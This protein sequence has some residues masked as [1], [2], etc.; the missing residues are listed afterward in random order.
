MER[1]YLAGDPVTDI[2][3]LRMKPSG[4]QHGQNPKFA[5]WVEEGGVNL[6]RNTL[7]SMGFTVDL[8][9]TEPGEERELRA[10]AELVCL[11]KKNGKEIEVNPPTQDNAI[12]PVSARVKHYDGYATQQDSKNVKSSAKRQET[13]NRPEA[14]DIVFL[15]DAGAVIRDTDLRAD[16]NKAASAKLILHK[17]HQALTHDSPIAKAVQ[18]LGAPE[19]NVL[20]V[21]AVDVRLEGT[22]M[23]GNLSWDAA[24][25]DITS[26][27]RRKSGFLAEALN[28]YDHVIIVFGVD[29]V[30]CIHH[31]GNDTKIT[32]IYHPTSAE[33][34]LALK[35]PG[36][37]YGWTNS[38][39]C[40]FLAEL[41]DSD[42]AFP[43]GSKDHLKAVLTNALASA[44][45]Y[46]NSD[47]K[48]PKLDE[49]GED[50]EWPGVTWSQS[51]F[52]KKKRK[53]PVSKQR[54]VH[55][56]R[57]E[58]FKAHA[59]TLQSITLD[60][61]ELMGTSDRPFRLI[62]FVP[63]KDS[64]LELAHQI[65]V[66]GNKIMRTLPSAKIGD[67]VTLD[68]GE[69]ESYRSLQRM[70]ENYLSND[71]NTK[72]I[73]IGVFGPPGSGKSFGIKQIAKTMKI[74]I[75]E[76]NLSEAD[77]N[78]LP[79]YFHEIRDICLKGETPLCFFDEFD[80][81]GR[82][83]V[84]RFLAPMQDGEFRDGPRV[85]PVGRAILVFAGGT[86]QSVA[87]FLDRQEDGETTPD[88]KTKKVP[89]FV[90]RLGAT[91]DIMGPN[92][93]E[94]E[95][96][97][98]S[99]YLRRAVLMRSMLALHLPQLL[100]NGKGQAFVHPKVIDAFITADHY[101]FGARSL[102]QILKICRIPMGQTQFNLSD[103]PD[104]TR[105]QLHLRTPD[106]FVRDTPL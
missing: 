21:S 30:A 49:L 8:N 71:R 63:E 68:R 89:D 13:K 32:F 101:Q 86:A 34:D 37:L 36:T 58:A 96:G 64:T 61:K 7:T 48:I 54:R 91:L 82:E 19:R 93:T 10:L 87:E 65:I 3:I 60:L 76:F 53:G 92:P 6:T 90:S 28:H 81:N 1:V 70:I 78:A 105:L 57:Q 99:F 55:D 75:K 84:A 83:L 39:S 12:V 2:C 46:A 18:G 88:N 103:L 106:A 20:L 9:A 79:G 100:A 67:F 33:G 15:N 27:L 47:I 44:R 66:D 59:E 77:E 98:Q 35:R 94:T 102:E 73:S 5:V 23:R 29:A 42:V 43:H 69:I 45:T 56:A 14:C 41:R 51:V 62:E 16:L 104:S 50:L 40:A 72:P 26:A 74:P 25:D 85:H 95:D 97:S 38:F 31:E 52:E 4:G 80:S 17:M 22:R 24:L 11:G